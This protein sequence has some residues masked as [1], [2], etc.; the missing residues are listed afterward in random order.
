MN[1]RSVKM[2]GGGQP[3]VSFSNEAVRDRELRAIVDTAR[4]LA[5]PQRQPGRRNKKKQNQNN[6][7]P[8]VQQ[9]ARQL[10]GSLGVPGSVSYASSGNKG[11]FPFAMDE[12]VT[13]VKKQEGNHLDLLVIPINPG[14]PAMFALAS[15]P[16][17][18][19]DFWGIDKN[20]GDYLEVYWKPLVTEYKVGQ[21]N[22]VISVDYDSSDAQ[23]DSTDVMLKTDPHSEGMPHL[24]QSLRLDP[25]AM[26]KGGDGKAKYVR[27]DIVSG[28][29]KMYDG[30]VIYVAITGLP[31]DI[32]A[33]TALGEIRLRYRLR[34]SKLNPERIQGISRSAPR[35]WTTVNITS[36]MAN[37]G[38]ALPDT[39]GTDFADLQLFQFF[40]D[41]GL[42]PQPIL[43]G[44]E[45][46]PYRPMDYPDAAFPKVCPDENSIKLPPGRYLLVLNYV[47]VANDEGGNP[48]NINV[49]R[50]K[51]SPSGGFQ[52][53]TYPQ[54]I[55]TTVATHHDSSAADANT[56]TLLGTNGSIVFAIAG[57]DEHTYYFT[58]QLVTRAQEGAEFYANTSIIRL[59]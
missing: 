41:Y 53:S 38:V 25:A 26:M 14:L 54:W 10:A 11:E 34:F 50:I 23:P 45:I 56:F 1:K 17:Q 27:S 22:V 49:L 20:K 48:G 12:I 59:Q 2:N 19:Y 8:P 36:A 6:S 35:N 3:R 15:V 43:Y 29:L 9:Q 58:Y 5:K 18:M 4:A 37:Q 28:D 13:T 52:T 46:D 39:G 47:V 31:D 42:E 7:T 44:N 51:I 40:W 21:G 33:G 24:I 55:D 57:S 30:G 32:D 16:G